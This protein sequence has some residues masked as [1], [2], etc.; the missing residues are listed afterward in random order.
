[1]NYDWLDPDFGYV[2]NL[3]RGPAMILIKFYFVLWT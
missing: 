2:G 1:M 3:S